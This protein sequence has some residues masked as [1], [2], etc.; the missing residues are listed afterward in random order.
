MSKP[1]EQLRAQLQ[2]NGEIML[3]SLVGAVNE[4]QNAKELFNVIGFSSFDLDKD[5]AAN[6][7]GLISQSNQLN[8]DEML[9]ASARR[10]M[11]KEAKVMEE[12]M[13]PL[14]RAEYE[15]LSEKSKANLHMTP[16]ASI[17]VLA[18]TKYN[19][20]R[21]KL[22][23]SDEIP[24]MGDFPMPIYAYIFKKE[25]EERLRL[26]TELTN[27]LSEIV[28]S[29]SFSNEQALAM[30]ESIDIDKK[31]KSIFKHSNGYSEEKFKEDCLELFKLANGRLK[32]GSITH[33]GSQI[34]SFVENKGDEGHTLETGMSMNRSTTWHNLGHVIEERNPKA[35]QM[36]KALL[37]KRLKESKTTG[38]NGGGIQSLTDLTGFNYQQAE[39]IDDSFFT[40][41]AGK[42]DGTPENTPYTEII[43]TGLEWLSSPVSAGH[44][45]KNDPEHAKTVMLILRGLH[46]D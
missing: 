9:L 16:D 13:L 39:C 17:R 27:L 44:F 40:Y 12:L 6:I 5:L 3:P 8:D 1:V 46:N 23:Q 31:A 21:T 15:E 19:H 43:S 22:E 28:E 18:E 7:D 42:L 14:A 34:R 33:K 29:S 36:T 37:A 30:Y 4:C 2:E 24:K 38:K 20:F 41:Y 11:K 26:G 35:M 25:G 32:I 10:A 45:L